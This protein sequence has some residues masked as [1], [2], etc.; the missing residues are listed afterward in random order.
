MYTWSNLVANRLRDV[1]I[2]PFGP[3][4]YLFVRVKV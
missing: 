2:P 4:E 1:T 3:R